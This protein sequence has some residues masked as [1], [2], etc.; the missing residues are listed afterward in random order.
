MPQ[1]RATLA[2]GA[3]KPPATRSLEPIDRAEV[4]RLDAEDLAA[5]RRLEA[6]GRKE[7]S[8]V[9]HPDAVA[10]TAY[11][12]DRERGVEVEPRQAQRGVTGGL[13]ERQL[14]AWIHDG[15][16]IDSLD[17][18]WI[19]DAPTIEGAHRVPRIVRIDHRQGHTAG[20]ELDRRRGAL[21][22]RGRRDG[23]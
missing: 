4:V 8:V 9:D 12:L 2:S 3:R 18:A 15:N 22:E 20:A 14:V 21:F 17:H 11:D 7:V 10:R 13:A 19:L 6:R 1:G 5:G 16:P 23:G